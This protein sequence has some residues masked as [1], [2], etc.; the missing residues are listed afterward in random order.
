LRQA[1]RVLLIAQ[2]DEKVPL[3]PFA[4][5]YFKREMMTPPELLLCIPMAA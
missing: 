1:D 3:Y 4:R 5:R 2:A